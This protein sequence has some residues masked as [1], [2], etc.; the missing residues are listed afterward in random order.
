MRALW[1]GQELYVQLNHLH[2]WLLETPF[3]MTILSGFEHMTYNCYVI[4]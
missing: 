3:S 2:A 4:L 1:L